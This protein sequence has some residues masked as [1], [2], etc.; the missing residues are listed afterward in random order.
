MNILLFLILGIKI[1][2]VR[3]Y[4]LNQLFC[5]IFLFWSLYTLTDVIIYTTAANNELAYN[6]AIIFWYLQNLC[7]SWICLLILYASNVIRESSSSI[8]TSHI[9][10]NIIIFT[11]LGLIISLFSQIVILDETK[12][13]IA[14]NQASTAETVNIQALLDLP[15]LIASIFLLCL[16]LFAVV[17]LI[18]TIKHT[19]TPIIKRKMIQLICGMMLLPLGMIYFIVQS[20]LGFYGFWEI[21]IGHFMWMLSPIIIWESQRKKDTSK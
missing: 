3:H 17:R 1:Y 20:Q 21:F 14:I 12:T 8:E 2:R 15:A 9:P 4:I 5:G 10:L 19:S 18:P 6:I 13:M 11:I 16:Y 7:A